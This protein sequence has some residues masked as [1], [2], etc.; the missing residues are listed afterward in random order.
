[1]KLIE[2][3]MLC[4]DAADQTELLAHLATYFPETSPT[5]LRSAAAFARDRLRKDDIEY[6]LG[7]L[8]YPENAELIEQERQHFAARL[9]NAVWHVMPRHTQCA[10]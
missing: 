6:G 5:E 9:Q 2:F 10:N 8:A 1:M 7:A 3:F 4:D